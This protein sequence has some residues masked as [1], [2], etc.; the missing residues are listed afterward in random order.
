M[1]TWLSVLCPSCRPYDLYCWLDSLYYKALNPRQ[2]ELSLTV[3]NLHPKEYEELKEKWGN[4]K[5]TV[6]IHGEY[7]INELVEI[8]YKQ[9]TSPF[10][11]LSGDDSI[12]H[13][14]FWD[15][16]LRDT[17][18]EYPDE[19]VLAY[20][21]DLI[22][23]DALACYP[24]TSRLIMDMM[25]WPLPMKR[26]AI[27]D[28]IFDMVPHSRRIYRPDIVMEHCHLVDE[29][30]G[31]PVYRDGKL[32]YYPINQE[33]MKVER[34]MYENMSGIRAEIRQ[35]LSVIAGI[36]TNTRVMVGVPTAEFAR[37][38]DFYD[39]L[40]MMEKPIGTMMTSTHGQ[41]PARSRNMIIESA[42]ERECTHILF[43][44]DDMCFKSDLLIRLLSHN[45]DIVSGLY[46]MRN[47]PHL[48]VMFDV[49]YDDGKCRFSFLHSK[50]NGLKEVVNC[51]LGACLIKMDVFKN[52]DKPWITLGE[53]EK[54]HW[55]DD[56]AFFL[57]ARKAGYKIYV[58]TN[59]RCGH[60]ISAAI[61]PHKTEDGK[62]FTLYNTGAPETF[63]VPQFLPSDEEIA[64]LTK[65]NGLIEVMV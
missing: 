50:V 28:T 40:N 63:Q 43:L 18:D 12:C 65:D 25:P 44:D 62:W 58:D 38:A 14:Q 60:I 55:C 48:P 2:I 15:K 45:K 31:Q 1:N 49:A 64:K 42:I 56:I 41:S 61:W 30:P 16:L 8:C 57:R 7:A 3:E 11:L 13:T 46:L 51:G 39:Y 47:Y 34:P 10:I 24:C 19:V 36:D 17:I 32:K 5:F 21:N 22:F 33:I 35:K 29:G 6:V 26:Y 54:D 52:M 59:A 20:P 23:G 37:R 9:S 4:I 27:D 53:I